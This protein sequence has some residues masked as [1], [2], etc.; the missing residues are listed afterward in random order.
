M[1]REGGR[2]GGVTN[3]SAP[4]RIT[5]KIMSRQCLFIDRL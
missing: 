2:E 1:E 5:D 4:K 3:G